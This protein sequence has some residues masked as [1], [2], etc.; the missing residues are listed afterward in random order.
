MRTE[1][2]ES[3]KEEKRDLLRRLVSNNITLDEYL[4]ECKE[5]SE[6]IK[7]EESVRV[8]QHIQ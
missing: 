2:I 7:H 8:S 3:L 1:D 4:E 5:I 6:A